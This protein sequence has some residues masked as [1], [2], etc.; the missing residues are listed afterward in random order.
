M[1]EQ[2][3]DGRAPT[4]PAPARTEEPARQ[5]SAWR[6]EKGTDP[7][8]YAVAKLTFRADDRL[9]TEAYYDAAIKAAGEYQLA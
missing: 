6:D 5:A 9:M 4:E 1:A 7:A 2:K 8:I 3:I